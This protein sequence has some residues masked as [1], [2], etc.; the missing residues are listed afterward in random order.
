MIGKEILVCNP[1]PKAKKTA[2]KSVSEVQKL[3][4]KVKKSQKE[5]KHLK[6]KR[7]VY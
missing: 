6:L 7:K 2:R 5:L 1:R 3:K 4:E